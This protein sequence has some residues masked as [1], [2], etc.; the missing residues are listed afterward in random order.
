MNQGTRTKHVSF[1]LREKSRGKFCLFVCLFL[2]SCYITIPYIENLPRL[3]F[4]CIHDHVTT[5]L[6]LTEFE[7]RTVSAS[8]LGQKSTGRN[9]D[10]TQFTNHTARVLTERYNNAC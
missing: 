9:E 4:E 8:C 6:L 5:H 7:V 10:H 1:I 3:F 2:L